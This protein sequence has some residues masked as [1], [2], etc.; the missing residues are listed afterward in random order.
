[1]PS[2]AVKA[3]VKLE[4]AFRKLA[5]T[6]QFTPDSGGVV[7]NRSVVPHV[8]EPDTSQEYIPQPV[9]MAEFLLSDGPVHC[10]DLFQLGILDGQG[11][12][13]STGKQCRLT[14]IY[15]VDN[16]SVIYIYVEI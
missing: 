9:T 6:C 8:T 10:D 15:Q 12:F 3:A 13:Q 14:Q 5:D 1:M 11:D 4:R 2:F 7:A 16:I